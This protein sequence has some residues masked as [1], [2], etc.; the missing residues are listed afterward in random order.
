M[1]LNTNENQ[2][3]FLFWNINRAWDAANVNKEDE[4]HI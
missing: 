1:F 4:F 3:S 2:Y